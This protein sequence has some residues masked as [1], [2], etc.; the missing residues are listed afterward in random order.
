MANT[1]SINVRGGQVEGSTIM[2][3]STNTGSS[4]T[5]IG[6]G[7]TASTGSVNIQ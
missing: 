5:A 4:T 3:N 6:T 2:N 7:N 1:G